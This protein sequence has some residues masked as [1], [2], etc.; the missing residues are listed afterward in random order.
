MAWIEKLH[1]TY[2][3]C[4][5][6]EPEGAEGLM[7]ISHAMQQAHIEIT[8][9]GAGNFKGARVIQKEE[10]VVPAT[11]QSAGRT[12]KLPPPHPLCDKVQYCAMDYPLH[13]GA[14]PSFFREYEQRLTAWCQSQSCSHP[15]ARAVLAYVGKGTLV[16]DLVKDRVLHVDKDGHLLT[17]WKEEG[18]PPELFRQLTPKDGL[19]D[20]GDA[21]IRWIVWIEGDLCAE[22]WKDASLQEAWIGFDSA[23]DAV[24]GLCMATGEA[25]SA[26]ASS[27]PKRIRHGGDGAKLISA[28]DGSGFTF[29]GRFTDS[30]GRQAAG[31]GYVTT[32]KAHS[33][34]RWLIKRQAYRNGDQAFV[35]W[36]VAGKPIPD[37]WADSRALI[38]GAGLL[39][40]QEPD[41]A[42]VLIGDAGQAFA[43]RLRRAIAG[44]RAKLDPSD[45]VVVIGLDSATPGRMAIIYYRELKGSDFLQRIEA[46]HAGYAWPQNFGKDKHF[47]GAPAPHDIAEASFGRRLDE[48]LKKST[49]ERLLPCIV[50]GRTIPRDLVVSAV[51]RA[52]NRAGL[53]R[54]EWEKILGIACGLFRGWSKSLG[55]EYAMALEGDR[56]SRDYLYGRL[57]AV[58][59]N[60][61]RYALTAAEKNRDTMAGRLMQRFAERPF[62]TWRIIEPALTPY[63]TR[64]RASDNSAGFLWKREKLID[65]IHCRF[66]SAD[67]T[68]DSALSGEFLLGYHCQR[69]AFFPGST[70]PNA[71]QPDSED[72]AS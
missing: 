72:E 16:A 13:G 53:E 56:A 58:A 46:W 62:S 10:T 15:K 64:L 52:A 21:F 71:D 59:D 12:G 66:A 50:D 57:L 55:E 47:T 29:R 8:I 5:G 31:V 63:K 38:L 54:W 20:Q 68:D 26:L 22:V 34:L 3:A 48:K 69:A 1:A 19:R 35:A 14:K 41:E 61:E 45:D 18:D 4:K 25:D 2:E 9:D 42:Q 33:A 23:N 17:Q 27:H 37:P 67:F 65:E 36:A 44:Y 11:E 30:D 6:R 7:P 43:R 28:N 49:V 32:Q 39:S 60:I 70:S 40:Q 51:R 24:K